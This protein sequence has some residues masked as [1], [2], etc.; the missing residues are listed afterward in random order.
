MKFSLYGPMVDFNAFNHHIEFTYEFDQEIIS[1]LDLKVISSNAKL[2]FMVNLLIDISIFTTNEVIKTCSHESDF[3]EHSSK[4]KS[5][6]LKRGYPEKNIETELK[7]VLG[8]KNKKVNYKKEKGIPF[9]FTFYPRLKV[10]Q[11]IVYK[12]LYVL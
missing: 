7:N 4:L 1:F 11:K 5:W 9:V 6:F 3:K 10:L 12:N 2:L 8:D